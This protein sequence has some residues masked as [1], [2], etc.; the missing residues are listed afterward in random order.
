MCSHLRR[1][2][3]NNP[4]VISVRDVLRISQVLIAGQ[5]R[6]CFFCFDTNSRVQLAGRT[7]P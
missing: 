3:A 1:C 7:H 6:K 4:I 5:T 2:F